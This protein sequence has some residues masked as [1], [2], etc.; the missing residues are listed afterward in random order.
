MRRGIF[1]QNM[2]VTLIMH[3]GIVQIGGAEIL[4]QILEG[5]ANLN[6]VDYSNLVKGCAEG[7]ISV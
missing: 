1:Y 7:S 3:L 4:D 2:N 6:E 5:A